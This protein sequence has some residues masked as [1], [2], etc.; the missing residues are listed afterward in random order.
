MERPLL[1]FDQKYY[2]SGEKKN[3][4]VF[5]DFTAKQANFCVRLSGSAHRSMRRPMI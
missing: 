1:K 4:L 3:L 5:D 2:G